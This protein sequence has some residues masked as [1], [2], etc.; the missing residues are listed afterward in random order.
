[1]EIAIQLPS[2]EELAGDAPVV[3]IGPNGSG[4]TRQTRGITADGPI[5]F[6]NALRN[7]L[8]AP[9]LPAMGFDTARNNFLAQKQQA[10]S[11]HWELT[12]EFDYMLSQLLAED[13]MAAKDFIRRYREDRQAVDEPPV[14]PLSRVE[15]L[16]DRIYP[17]RKLRWRD[18]RPMVA[19]TVTGSEVEYTA[20]QMSDGEKAALYVAGRAFSAESGVLV[21]DEPETHFHSRLA[22]NLWNELE[23]ARP[24]LRFVYVTHDLPFALSRPKAQ[25]VIANPTSGLRSLELEDGLPDDVA[26]ALLGSATLSFYASRVI[27]YKG[28]DGSLD[29][30]LYEAWFNGVDTVVRPVEDCQTVIR[31]VDAVQASG[32]ARGLLPRL[33]DGSGRGFL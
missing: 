12:S 4:K 32:I 17:G 30:M 25:Y 10:R 19:S 15:D 5:E 1:V 2:G 27:F 7:T 6:V 16:W 3:V 18:W 26:E 22:V 9:E 31:C 33:V 14:T 8:V 13:S 21:I 29:K 11:T 20:N 23:D 24:D 28:R